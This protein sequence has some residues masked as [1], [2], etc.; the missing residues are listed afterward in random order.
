[1][2]EVFILSCMI[3]CLGGTIYVIIDSYINNKVIREYYKTI[4]KKE[5]EE[6]RKQKERDEYYGIWH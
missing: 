1:M 2:I 5:K 6:K 4:K 3:V